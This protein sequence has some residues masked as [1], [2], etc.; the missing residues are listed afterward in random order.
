MS[1]E[2][3]KALFNPQEKRV[4]DAAT[5]YLGKVPGNYNGSNTAHVSA[6]NNFYHS[7]T[8]AALQN[9]GDIGKLAFIKAV[10]A[11]PM[12]KQAS[13]LAA[14]TVK[15]EKLLGRSVKSI[16]NAA[17]LTLP[18]DLTPSDSDRKQL[19]EVTQKYSVN[20]EAYIQDAAPHNGPID[21]Y[22]TAYSAQAARV[23]QYVNAAKPN[24]SP[25]APLDSKPTPSS[26]E[27]GAY[28]RTLN[29]AQQPLM[30]LQHI[31]NGTLTPKD[32]TDMN[33]MHPDLYNKVAAKLTE[34]MTEA[35]YKGV[36]IPYKTRLGLSIF[37]AKPLDSSMTAPGIATAQP[38]PQQ[39]P[40]P[41]MPGKAPSKSSQ[42]GLQKL[43]G[44]YQTSTQ[45]R[46]AAR[47][48]GN[49]G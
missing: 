34:A 41:P 35:Q 23:V 47:S 11:D 49:K 2:M 15:G 6:L 3:Q 5:T 10:H 32:V 12:V 20:P 13:A 7:P 19:H 43:P 48:S 46:Q 18:T 17:E 22:N 42:E 30:P 9:A 16:F 1:P 39:A 8:G 26:A 29:N 25:A 33:A 38:A 27:K 28:N 31:K 44:M 14:S 4:L 40:Q 45:S 21:K 36:P 24:T 37:L